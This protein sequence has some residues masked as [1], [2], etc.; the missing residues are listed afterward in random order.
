[1]VIKERAV[2]TWLLNPSV[3]K[4]PDNL[5]IA[6]LYNKTTENLLND[7]F[8]GLINIRNEPNWGLPELVMPSFK[9][10]MEKSAPAFAKI[11]KNLSKE[12]GDHNEC[13]ILLDCNYTVFY[14]FGDGCLY[15]WY[16][17]EVLD[18][19]VFLFSLTAEAF[20]DH[21]RLSCNE[22]LLMTF[23]HNQGTKDEQLYR[24]L[25]SVDF[26]FVY[27]AVK[28]YVPVE[29]VVIPPGKFTAIDGTPLQY[30]EKKKVINQLGQEVIVMDSKWFRK[31][32]NDNDIPV[33]GFFRMQNKKNSEGEW[34][35]ELIFVNPFV[36]HGY[37][38][39]ALIEQK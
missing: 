11:K 17:K 38:R 34:F 25:Q 28:K 24:L 36:R 8:E 39:D 21:I 2:I 16:F 10:V 31:I 9:K 12:F 33:R 22:D 5:V 19:S 7:E 15:V 32:I 20:D 29:T 23:S 3:S 14:G 18:K 26:I 6:R 35:K 4:I 30:V 37:H 27:A 13:G 1:M